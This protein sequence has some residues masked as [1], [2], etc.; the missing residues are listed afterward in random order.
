M[1]PMVAVAKIENPWANGTDGTD[2]EISDFEPCEIC[3]TK[4][5]WQPRKSTAWK[6]WKC[7]P[8]STL[9]IVAATRGVDQDGSD[10]AP[11]PDCS[12]ALPKTSSWMVM[13]GCP[14]CTSCQGSLIVEVWTE[15]STEMQCWTCKKKF[16]NENE[17]LPR[18]EKIS[19]RSKGAPVGPTG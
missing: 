13:H 6:C 14:R 2:Q 5:F 19:K 3:K 4:K 18:T 8:P 15:L 11:A 12:L 9:A 10:V 17:L 7:Q 16:K 1:G